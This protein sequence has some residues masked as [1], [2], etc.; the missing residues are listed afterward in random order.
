MRLPLTV[1]Q[2]RGGA[3]EHDAQQNQHERWRKHGS[4]SVVP[5]AAGSKIFSRETRRRSGKSLA[6]ICHRRP[7]A[8]PVTGRSQPESPSNPLS[9]VRPSA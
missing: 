1:Q 3:H 7:P 2:Q 8:P 6:P 9:C 5:A 4:A